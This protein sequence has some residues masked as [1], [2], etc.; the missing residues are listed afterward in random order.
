MK[1]VLGVKKL[2]KMQGLGCTRCL[3]STGPECS[4]NICPHCGSVARLL[5]HAPGKA[6]AQP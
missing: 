2:S 3:E 1:K 5:S 4:S 6:A